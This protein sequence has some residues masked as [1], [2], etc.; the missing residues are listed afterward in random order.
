[1]KRGFGVFCLVMGMVLFGAGLSFGEVVHNVTD[2]A[3]FVAA[4]S[5]AESNGD[6]DRINLAAGTYDFD[7]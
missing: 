6:D 7:S 2:V 3:G 4:L 1:M 5:A